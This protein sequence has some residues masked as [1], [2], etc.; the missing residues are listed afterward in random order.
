[1]PLGLTRK[2]A[3]KLIEDLISLF[4]SLGIDWSWKNIKDHGVEL[5]VICSAKSQQVLIP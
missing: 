1:M 5:E 2:L 4:Q 3:F